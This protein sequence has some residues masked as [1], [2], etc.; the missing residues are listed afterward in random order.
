MFS[1]N[2]TLFIVKSTL[3]FILSFSSLFI[4]YR[5]FPVIDG[6]SDKNATVSESK[7]Y[8]SSSSALYV[9]SADSGTIKQGIIINSSN[10]EPKYRTVDK[11]KY[12]YF[13]DDR[14]TVIE[15]DRETEFESGRDRGLFLNTVF[16]NLRNIS[17]DWKKT[18][19]INIF[20]LLMKISTFVLLLIFISRTFRISN[21]P[22]IN[23][24]LFI[25]VFFTAVF[26]LNISTRVIIPEPVLSVLPDFFKENWG[27]GLLLII[28]FLS[29][30]GKL[31][32]DRR[33]TV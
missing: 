12:R 30:A 7:F 16:N 27:Y 9:I 33:R 15:N 11:L 19:I 22:F 23:F 1:R 3:F 21:F 25:S 28:S 2:K 8:Y 17:N 24:S 31:I 13:S 20:H 18:A 5:F 4:S 29:L 6:F 32:P 14:F 10:E 26:F